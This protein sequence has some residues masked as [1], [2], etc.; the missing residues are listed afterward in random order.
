MAAELGKMDASLQEM[1]KTTQSMD[2]TLKS[3]TKK[4]GLGAGLAGLFS[5]LR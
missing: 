5:L 2:H 3:A 4:A 1:V